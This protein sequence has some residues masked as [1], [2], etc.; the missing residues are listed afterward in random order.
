ML[1]RA[2]EAWPLL[3]PVVSGLHHTEIS[4]PRWNLGGFGEASLLR[5]AESVLRR[6]VLKWGIDCFQFF[7]FSKEHCHILY[8]KTACLSLWHSSPQLFWGKYK[9]RKVSTVP[10]CINLVTRLSLGQ[11]PL[12]SVA[13]ELKEES[14]N[15][16][17]ILQK[18]LSLVKNHI[19]VLQWVLP[20]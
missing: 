7:A 11:F 14:N 4:A 1:L 20:Y 16:F 15:L 9:C 3:Y 18:F 6:L 19:L 2:C 17:K 12:P 8:K 5:T 10:A 13:I